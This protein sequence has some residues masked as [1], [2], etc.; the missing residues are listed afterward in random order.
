MKSSAISI[1]ALGGISRLDYLIFTYSF[2][3]TELAK[4]RT[5]LVACCVVESSAN[6]DDIDTNTL[7]VVI[8]RA[9]RGGDLPYST[10]STIY[11]QLVSTIT[12]PVT[13]LSL[14]EQEKECLVNWYKPNNQKSLGKGGGEDEANPKSPVSLPPGDIPIGQTG[15]IPQGEIA[16]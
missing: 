7:R 14:T 4:K 1:D 3:S 16:A 6:I 8:S 10:L 11:A 2:S 9:F 13:A 5:C 12:T 15:F